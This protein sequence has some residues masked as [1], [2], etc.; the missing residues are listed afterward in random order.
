M[1]KEIR[2][3]RKKLLKESLRLRDLAN[4]TP[5]EK[6]FEIRD[7]QNDVYHKWKFYDGIIKADDKINRK[8]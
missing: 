4:E 6:G 8:H 7:N 1:K 5:G 3:K 2:D